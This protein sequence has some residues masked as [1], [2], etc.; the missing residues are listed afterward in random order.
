MELDAKQVEAA[1]RSC[2][3]GQRVVPITGQAGTGKTTLMKTVHDKF[4][5]A[6][7]TV[8]LCAPTG[9]AAKRISEATSL[10]A[11]TIHRLLEYPKPG[12]IDEK[13]GK[14]L[15]TTRPRRH[16]RYPLA[17]NIV[18]VDE[19]AMVDWTLHTDLLHAIPTGG[20]IRMFGD[21]NQL[22]PIEKHKR[23]VGEKTPFAT[24]L[25]KFDGVVLDT[26][27]RQ[28][29]GSGIILNGARILAGR[30]PQRLDDFTIQVTDRP[31]DV[32]KRYILEQRENGIDF[33]SIAH[34][35]VTPANKT[36][37]GVYKL[38]GTLQTIF[39]PEIHD[40]HPMPR[41]QWHEAVPLRLHVGDKIL[42][43]ENNY[44][45]NIMNGE[46]GIVTSIDD[47]SSPTIDFGDRIQNVPTS[48][49][50]Q[51]QD[52]SWYSYDPRR[53]L[54]LAY[55]ITTHKAQGSEYS[56]VVYILNRSSLYVQ[57]QHNFYTGITRARQHVHL[58]TD[59]VSLTAS[60]RPER[61]G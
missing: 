21:V 11:T 6:G 15:S 51:R 45:L 58:I 57:G 59:Q 49:D 12:E 30:V 5:E 36:W 52:G 38:N 10:Q 54:Q 43:T 61:R 27:H 26:I 39:R 60:L 31:I 1:A 2:D 40:W 4:V 9:K 16:N 24:M 17:Q 34:Q 55:A 37:V 22:P 53:S 20:A 46:T 13:T 33:S 25:K 14:P 56:F 44:D 18:L 35:I 42:W 29:E 41:Y 19:Y 48:I 23:V 7:H 8:A 28:G 32:L 47:D 3:V 50:V